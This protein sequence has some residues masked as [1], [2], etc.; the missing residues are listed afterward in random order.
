MKIIFLGC[1]KFSEELLQDILLNTSVEIA[2]IFTIPQDFHISYSKTKV[3]NTNFS[4]LKPY[5][6]LHN[7]PIYEV[8]SIRGKRI[9]DYKILLQEIKPDVILVLG[10]YY[11]VPKS[12]RD[13]AKLG[14]WGIHASLLPRYAGGAPLVWAMI[15]GEKE[16][17]K[18]K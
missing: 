7:I 17:G 13:L 14:A 9:T 8:D 1:T 18:E 15:N 2:A 11:M 6:V 4:D 5:A 16:S 12:I 3:H 10:W